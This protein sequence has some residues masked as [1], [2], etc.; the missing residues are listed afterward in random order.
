[1]KLKISWG[2]DRISVLISANVP[3]IFLLLFIFIFLCFITAGLDLESLARY[4]K[5]SKTFS[6]L[7]Q[8]NHFTFMKCLMIIKSHFLLHPSKK[9]W[10]EHGCRTFKI[11][12][13]NPMLQPQNFQH[14]MVEKTGVDS[15]S[16]KLGV[17]KSGVE[18]SYNLEHWG[19]ILL[20]IKY[21]NSRYKLGAQTPY[22]WFTFSTCDWR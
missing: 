14:K 22:L 7:S 21:G 1:M 13:L 17:E 12:F 2:N 8:E 19:N 16:I 20:V 6:K 15:S 18:M 5:V 11:R 10:L 3:I 4:G 9:S